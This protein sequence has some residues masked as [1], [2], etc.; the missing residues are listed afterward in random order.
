MSLDKHRTRYCRQ[1][2]AGGCG[3]STVHFFFFSCTGGSN[4]ARIASSKTFFSPFCT[5][6]ILQ[7]SSNHLSVKWQ[8]KANVSIQLNWKSAQNTPGLEQSTQRI[9]QP[10][11]PWPIARPGQTW[12]ASGDSWSTSQ[13]RSI[14]HAN[15]PACLLVETESFGSGEWF[16][17]PTV[18]KRLSYAMLIFN[19]IDLIYYPP[20]TDES[21][22][23]PFLSRSRKMTAKWPRSKQEKRLS[24]GSSAG[25]DDHNLPG[26]PCQTDPECMARLRSLQ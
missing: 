9:W 16:L 24:E 2:E 12:W 18:Q 14:R 1:R 20:K 25:E 5:H 3:Q 22:D 19:A 8:S 11:V 17:G 21:L 23:K 10:S 4:A 7:V 6:E 26:Q 15:P 13:R